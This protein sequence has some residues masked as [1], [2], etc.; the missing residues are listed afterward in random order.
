M[1]EE[2][3][4]R[5]L[6]RLKSIVE[7]ARELGGREGLRERTGSMSRPYCGIGFGRV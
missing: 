6:V 4:V 1:L 3:K 2:E 7:V 5:A